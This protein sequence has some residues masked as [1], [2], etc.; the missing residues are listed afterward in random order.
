VIARSDAAE[1][2]VWQLEARAR[3]PGFPAAQRQAF[4]AN[5]LPVNWTIAGRRTFRVRRRCSI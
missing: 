2:F 5:G 3:Q 4:V 1:A